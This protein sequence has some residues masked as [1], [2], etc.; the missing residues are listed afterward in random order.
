M[1]VM[2]GIV[3]GGIFVAPHV[4]ARVVHTPALILGVW[5]AGTAIALA[6]AFIYAELGA[7]RPDTGGQYAYLRDAFHP[8]VGFLYGWALLFVIMTGAL[9]LMAVTFARYFRELTAVPL[10][11]P[12]LAAAGILSLVIV[13]CLGV[14]SG[15]RV[16]GA[17]MIVKILVL[18]I[19]VSAGLFVAPAAVDASAARTEPFS[20]ALL[21][22]FGAAMTPVMFSYGGWQTANFVAGEVRDPERNLALG[23]IL[24]VLGVG[25]LYLTVNLACLH[26]LGAAG[27][28][29][30]DAPASAVMRLAFGEH[31]AKLMAIGITMSTLGMLSQ[32]MLVSPRVYFAMAADGVFF[33]AIAHVN[34]RTR[35]PVAAIV[36]QG[37]LALLIAL[38]GTFEEILNYVT[39]VDFVF[40]GLSASTLFV[41]RSR[42]R[43]N[44]S[45]G[46]SVTRVPGHPVTT[47]LFV[48]ACALI[49]ASTVYKDPRN[50]AI[51]LLLVLAGVP[52]FFVWRRL[53][54]S[55]A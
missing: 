31:G 15:S 19:L 43:G 35:A 8:L 49:V 40:F 23:I 20:F 33:R 3:G 4:V 38:S 7:R 25:F 47:G 16:Q 18:L 21:V 11:E 12:V 6:G 10:D 39:S 2:G 14:R 54:P 51:G 42:D 29:A 26:A 37:V 22:S 13:N 5:V 45:G 27:L 41:F 55:R 50:S 34:A 32:G 9:A 36:L 24:G 1:I 48:L 44:A 52:V 28:E 53:A 30:S 46:S 17:L